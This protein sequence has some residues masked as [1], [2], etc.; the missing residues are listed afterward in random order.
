MGRGAA[1]GCG[2]RFGRTSFEAALIVG[3]SNDAAPQ[4]KGRAG[5]Q[6][7]VH[8]IAAKVGIQRPGHVASFPIAAFAGMTTTH[9][10]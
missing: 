6:R 5:G 9:P 4:D 3:L 8:T 7:D 2:R 10:I 1:A